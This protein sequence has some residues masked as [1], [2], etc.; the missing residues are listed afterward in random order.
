MVLWKLLERESKLSMRFVLVSF[1]NASFLDSLLQVFV[2]NGSLS[3]RCD[4][5]FLQYL[6]QRKKIEAEE[7]RFKQSKARDDFVTMLEVS[8][9][10]YPLFIFVSC[11]HIKCFIVIQEC[12]ELTSS[13]RW[14]YSS[15][16]WLLFGYNNQP[17]YSTF[18]FCRGSFSFVDHCAAKQYSCLMMMK[19]SKLL[20]VQG[21][22][23]I[24]L[25]TILWNY[26]KRFFDTKQS[27]VT[28]VVEVV[29]ILS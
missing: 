9:S 18:F 27:L 22:A 17:K 13:T 19:D 4:N 16:S 8:S 11:F 6:N 7:K 23:K 20:S 12:K 15:N 1:W 3:L 10:K 21:S 29:L 24:Y 26:I 25:R 28:P 5:L 14:R 2:A